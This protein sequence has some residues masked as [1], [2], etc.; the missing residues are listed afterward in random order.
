MK[1]LVNCSPDHLPR[2]DFG[3]RILGISC[4][5]GEG[6]GKHSCTQTHIVGPVVVVSQF[7]HAGGFVPLC[8]LV[9]ARLSEC[10]MT[11]VIQVQYF[12]LDKVLAH[13]ITTSAHRRPVMFFWFFWT[14]LLQKHLDGRD[15]VMTMEMIQVEGEMFVNLLVR[16]RPCDFLFRCRNLFG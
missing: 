4:S 3:F 12:V 7:F 15:L 11:Q 5:G 14:Q 13:F 10:F 6:G 2:G 1:I 9:P 8:S 16:G